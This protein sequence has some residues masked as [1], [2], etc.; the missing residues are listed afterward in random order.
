VARATLEP[1]E[2]RVVV[3]LLRSGLA[4]GAAFMLV[5][6]GL[7]LGEGRLVSHVVPIRKVWPWMLD[8]RPSG[9]MAAGV[10]VL[11]ATPFLRILALVVGFALDRD[12]RFVAVA[13]TVGAILALGI[14]LGRV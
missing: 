8:G 12:W 10:L 7:A 5:G 13:V 14:A 6:M 9:F 1:T 4:I 2:R 3:I 11:V